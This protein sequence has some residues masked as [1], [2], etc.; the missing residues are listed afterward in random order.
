[1]SEEKEKE[2]DNRQYMRV[3]PRCAGCGCQID[4]DLC[5]CGEPRTTH[6]DQNAGHSFV[7]IGCDCL[8]D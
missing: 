2:H 8:R 6:N 1:M 5:G 4:P 3:W 7:P